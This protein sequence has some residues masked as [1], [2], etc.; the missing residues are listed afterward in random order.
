MRLQG[1]LHGYYGAK[2]MFQLF[3]VCRDGGRFSGSKIGLDGYPALGVAGLG[4]KVAQV[5]CW[6]LRSYSHKVE[7]TLYI[8]IYNIHM[9]IYIYIYI[10]VCVCVFY[11]CMSRYLFQD[12]TIRSVRAIAE[13]IKDLSCRPRTWP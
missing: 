8:C 4:W 13:C 9:Y 12:T 2:M 5:C 7:C 1:C 10:C 6:T 11:V 3:S